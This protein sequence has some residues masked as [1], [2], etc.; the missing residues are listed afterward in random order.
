MHEAQIWFECRLPEPGWFLWEVDLFVWGLLFT[1]DVVNTVAD[2]LSCFAS[3]TSWWTCWGSSAESAAPLI[4][5]VLC[6]DF[7]PLT[8]I[9]MA[10]VPPPPP[11]IQE[12]DVF[13]MS[14]LVFTVVILYFEFKFGPFAPSAYTYCH[15]SQSRLGDYQSFYVLVKTIK[16]LVSEVDLPNWLVWG[17]ELLRIL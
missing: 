15:W 2:I 11:T 7:Q 16:Q 8:W 17:E 4:S 14:F 10:V 13:L 3:S 9:K 1:M 6:D 5:T 12:L